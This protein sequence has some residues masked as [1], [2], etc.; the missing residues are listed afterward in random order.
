ML[1]EAA[2]VSSFYL[3]IALA[4]RGL[5]NWLRYFP[6][7]T[8]TAK[9]SPRYTRCGLRVSLPSLPPFFLRAPHGFAG[10]PAGI[11]LSTWTHPFHITET[12]NQTMQLAPSR[13]AFTLHSTSASP[14]EGVADLFLVRPCEHPGHMQKNRW[15][16]P[17][18]VIPKLIHSNV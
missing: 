16:R 12:P 18:V 2:R 15:I 7:P 10:R 1:Y 11:C 8:S 13:T 5:T 9:L 17:S 4:S 6:I 14:P 3:P